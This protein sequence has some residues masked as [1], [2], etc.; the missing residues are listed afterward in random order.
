MSSLYHNIPAALLPAKVPRGNAKP[1]CVIYEIVQHLLRVAGP[2]AFAVEIERDLAGL[3]VGGA[4]ALA[5]D[6]MDQ[7]AEVFMIG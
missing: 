7:Q 2:D 3:A 4:V 6:F 1:A 5:S